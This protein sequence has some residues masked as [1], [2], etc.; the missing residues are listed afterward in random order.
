M[1]LIHF[2]KER[3]A[4]LCFS[5]RS[6]EKPD[7][8]CFVLAREIL[9]GVHEI[10]ERSRVCMPKNVFTSCH[11]V[12]LYSPASSNERPHLCSRKPLKIWNNHME[13]PP[14]GT[15]SQAQNVQRDYPTQ[16]LNISYDTCLPRCL[17][18]RAYH[19]RRRHLA[20]N[21]LATCAFVVLLL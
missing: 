19:L 7:L 12:L 17:C 9:E 21:K 10:N 11:C 8:R 13:E 5:R 6:T 15:Q 18:T 4:T 16:C 2:S 1:V 14:Y 20:A 3:R